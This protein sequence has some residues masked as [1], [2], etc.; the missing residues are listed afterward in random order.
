MAL[1][2]SQVCRWRAGSFDWIKFMFCRIKSRKFCGTFP[3]GNLSPINLYWF[4]SPCT[5]HEITKWTNDKV[6]PVLKNKWLCHL[7]LF[8][9][10]FL[11]ESRLFFE[12]QPEPKMIQIY[13]KSKAK[14][15]RHRIHP[16]RESPSWHVDG[17][18]LSSWSQI[19]RGIRNFSPH[20]NFILSRLRRP[21]KC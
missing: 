4:E 18:T 1:V 8:S 17:S 20:S 6:G 10:F 11:S 21:A 12:M 15:R 9:I 13:R 2:M 14:T 3:S 19:G 7:P 16:R 5:C